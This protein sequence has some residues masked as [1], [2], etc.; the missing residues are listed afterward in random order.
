MSNVQVIPALFGLNPVSI[1][2]VSTIS[3]LARPAS[4]LVLKRSQFVTRGHQSAAQ[5]DV[6]LGWP[7]LD[8]A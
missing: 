3:H 5:H 4:K 8:D 1:F 2:L 6:K 7:L